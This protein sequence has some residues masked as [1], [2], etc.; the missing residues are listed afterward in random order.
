MMTEPMPIRAKRLKDNG[1]F[2]KKLNS[3]KGSHA[4]KKHAGQSKEALMQ[5]IVLENR[6]GATTYSNKQKMEE[7]ITDAIMDKINKIDDWLQN[8]KD[9]PEYKIII[10]PDPGTVIGYGFTYDKKHASLAMRKTESQRIVLQRDN[11][12]PELGFSLKTA[13]PDASD[14]NE[15]PIIR[16][17]L[18][19]IVENTPYYEVMTPFQKG[20][21]QYCAHFKNFREG[22]RMDH[23]TDYMSFSF[24]YGGIFHELKFT[25]GKGTIAAYTDETKIK[26]IAVHPDF[27]D[28][29]GILAVIKEKFPTSGNA[30]QYAVKTACGLTEEETRKWFTPKPRKQPVPQ[31]TMD[32]KAQSAAKELKDTNVAK[33]NGSPAGDN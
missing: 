6:N 16:T 31:R 27:T 15:C 32:Q 29:R 7:Y 33:Q 10:K 22:C 3:G 17:R 23:D 13:F 12:V 4:E 30:L 18:P 21:W 28:G 11:T 14:Y 20:Y 2:F 25:P 1:T 5:R 8:Q 26:G 19:E 24:H 9:K